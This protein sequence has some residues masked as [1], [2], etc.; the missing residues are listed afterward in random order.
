MP[1]RAE[2]AHNDL[3]LIPPNLVVE[4][5]EV[6]RATTSA[7]VALMELDTRSRYIPNPAVL[8]NA[9]PVVEAQASSEI[10]NI[11]TTT[12]DMFQFDIQ[13][14]SA[15]DPATREA[16]RYRT[17]LR[18]GFDSIGQRPLSTSTAT[19]ICSAILGH[20]TPIRTDAGTFI[21]NP[22]TKTVTYTPP[23][24]RDNLMRL[25]SNWEDYI[26]R[27]DE[28]DPLVRL[29]VAHYQFEAI[30]PFPD[31]NGRT[32]RI[33]NL[34]LLA[35]WGLLELPVL[36]LSRYFIATKSEYYERLMGVTARGEWHEWILYF[37]RGVETTAL[38]A[39][40]TVNRI[41]HAH[42]DVQ[43]RIR[44]EFGTANSSLIDVL[45]TQPYSR[46]RDVVVGCRVSR[47]TATKWLGR[48]VSIGVLD[49]HRVGRDRLFV[50]RAFVAALY[51]D[52]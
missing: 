29:A 35:E 22:L 23:T 6:L 17:A 5:I 7:R 34:L 50:N 2:V 12:D 4:T 26:H 30:H 32:G 39:T 14:L 27:R 44:D 46:I 15:A 18:V 20:D 51:G 8:I 43:D 16:L 3:P 45:F 31:G 13:G 42:L 52:G 28:V 41:L 24:G 47:P 25:M 38:S 9:I 49:S 11:V 1:F 36:Y 33:L 10:E 19:S 40:A 48:L 37:V 21:G